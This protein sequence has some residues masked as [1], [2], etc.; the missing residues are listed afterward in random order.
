MKIVIKGDRNTGKTCLFQRLQGKPFNEQ[1]IPTN[2]IQVLYVEIKLCQ[3]AHMKKLI[4]IISSILLLHVVFCHKWC[5]LIGYTTINSVIQ[6]PVLDS[7]Q[8]TNERL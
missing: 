8:R 6:I 1:Y 5:S 7:E 4:I 3:Y 2:E